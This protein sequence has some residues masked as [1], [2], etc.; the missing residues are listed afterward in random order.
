[1]LYIPYDGK[2]TFLFL[3][4]CDIIYVIWIQNFR[5]ITNIS[6]IFNQ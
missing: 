5:F 3:N 4:E 6:G 1:M 2:Y